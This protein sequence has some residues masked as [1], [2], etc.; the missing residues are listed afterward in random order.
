[1]GRLC[2]FRDFLRN[3]LKRRERYV[4]IILIRSANARRCRK[5]I[6]MDN[7]DNRNDPQK[8]NITQQSSVTNDPH[9]PNN[10][11]K[12]ELFVGMNLLSKI[13]VI[14]IIIGV[15]AFSAA[16]EGYIPVAVRMGMVIAIGL[17]MLAGGE[18]FRGRGSVVFAN[19]LTY[20][21]IAELFICTLIGRFGFEVWNG[22]VAQL[23][24]LA[25][26]AVGFLLSVRCKSQPLLIVTQVFASLPIFA[27]EDAALAVA[28]AALCLMITHSAAAIIARKNDY[29]VS[30]I[31]GIVIGFI[32]TLIILGQ[33]T[34]VSFGAGE[35]F[36]S[37]HNFACIFSLIFLICVT[38]CYA[39]G[40]LLNAAEKNG[41]LFGWE[42]AALCLSLGSA[43][44]MITILLADGADSSKVGGIGD[45][46]FAVILGVIIAGFSLRF[47]KRCAAASALINIVLPALALSVPMLLENAAAYVALHIL[48]VLVM[49]LGLFTERKLLTGWGCALLIASEIAF[50]TVLAVTDIRNT[51]NNTTSPDRIISIIANL[52]LW[53]V[54]LVIFLIRKKHDSLGFRLY[55]CAALLNAGLLLCDLVRRDLFNAMIDADFL[56]AECAILVT[57]ICACIWL[58][59]GFAAGKPKYLGNMGMGFS[60]GFYTIGMGYLLV[61]NIFKRAVNLH[62]IELGPLFVIITIVVNLVSVLTVLDLTLQI[63]AKAPK[64]AKAIGLVV[65]GYALMSLTS[66][67]STNNMVAFTSWIISIIYIITAAVWIVIGFKKLN[68]LLRRF[69]LALAL[70]SSAKLF[71]F[72]FRGIDAMGRTLL[73]IGFGFTLLAISFGY[74]IAEKKLKEQNGK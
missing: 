65:S 30:I 27:A 38:V 16:S 61:N 4:I 58:A 43:L 25:A 45:I 51:I 35:L 37:E 46:V 67:L 11:S 20:G 44:L 28:A 41:R 36:P 12:G 24:G 48:A 1:M 72:D 5:E 31:T 10:V 57:L 60:I 47:D 22:T 19:A 59:L 14:F 26:A 70:L 63:T 73:F 18:F 49:T 3:A 71:L 34:N 40:M 68:A 74:G 66:V 64:F 7:L 55:T 21:G 56:T 50:F 2:F 39:G 32:H 33:F 8:Q 52:V 42:S 62:N 53:F 15:I 6:I 17:I 13:G 9:V 54:L 23:V 29:A 69:G